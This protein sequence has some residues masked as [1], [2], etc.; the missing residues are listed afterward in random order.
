MAAATG[1]TDQKRLL[2]QD[3]SANQRTASLLEKLVSKDNV[4]FNYVGSL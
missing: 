2:Q 3:V 1:V 4:E